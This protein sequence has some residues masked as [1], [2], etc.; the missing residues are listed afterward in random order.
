M[1]LFNKQTWSYLGL[2]LALTACGNDNDTTAPT[3]SSTTPASS[4]TSVARNSVITATFDG[5]TNVATFT[6]TSDLAKLATYTATLSTAITDLAGNPLAADYSWSFT[7]AGGAWRIAE[8][9]EANTGDAFNSQVAVDSSGNAI[10]V[11]YQYDG[12]R[13]NIVANRFQ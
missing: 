5:G 13:N 4:A 3:V 11:W 8:L 12:S 10:A 1:S 9:I 6:L 2:L 7:T